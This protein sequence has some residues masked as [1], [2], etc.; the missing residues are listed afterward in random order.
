MKITYAGLN[1]DS[2]KCANPIAV[3]SRLKDIVECPVCLK[4]PRYGAP[5]FQCRNGHL[6]CRECYKRVESTCP[7][8]R[9]DLYSNTKI[10]CLSAEKILDRLYAVGNGRLDNR[11]WSSE[12]NMKLKNVSHK[13]RFHV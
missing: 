10:R 11:L 3:Q 12:Q 13:V 1:G 9:V 2:F 4:T 5:I 6:I 7:V 8:C